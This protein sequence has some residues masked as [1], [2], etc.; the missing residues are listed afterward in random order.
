MIKAGIAGASRGTFFTRGGKDIDDLNLVAVC[1]LDNDK[2]QRMKDRLGKDVQAYTDYEQ[3]LDQSGIN[4]VIVATPMHLHAQHV[5]AAMERDIHVYCEVTPAV[6]IDECMRLVTAAKKSKSV[7]M[8]G[9]SF[10]YTRS[11]CLIKHLCEMGCF[12]DTYYAEGEYLH[13]LK[14]MNEHETPWRRTWQTGI[15]GV[16]YGTHSLGPILQW[17]QDRVVKVCCAAAGSRQTDQNGKPYCQASPV[18][19]CKTSRGGLIKIRVDMT[20]D[21]PH[22]MF[23]YVLQGT[24]GAYES[25]REKGDRDMIWLREL[26]KTPKWTDLN[27]F[28]TASPLGD[29]YAPERWH[30]PPAKALGAGHGGGDYFVIRDFADAALGKIKSPIGIH[31][32]MDMTLPGLISQQSILEDGRWLDVPDSRRW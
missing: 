24:D 25:A 22:S 16:T 28:W 21:R 12:G 26:S 20:S 3:M 15:D 2:L 1:D 8:L 7:F 9:E 31:E 23:N 29:K 14:H 17:M 6:S 10:A 11:N 5:M 19:L 32:T 30:H 18:M 4:A 27:A 13:E